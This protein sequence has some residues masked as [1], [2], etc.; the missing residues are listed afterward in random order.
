MSPPVADA[1]ENVTIRE[2]KVVILNGS[3]SHDNVGIDNYTWYVFIGEKVW[4]LWGTTAQFQFHIRGIYTVRLVVAD[5]VGLTDTDNLTV[6][7]LEK[8]DGDSKPP[9]DENDTDGDGWN[10]TIEQECGTDPNDNTSYPED[11]DDDG[12]PD[13]LDADIDGDGIPNEKDAYPRDSSRWKEED[14]TLVMILLILGAS[15]ILIVAGIMIYSRIKRRDILDNDT[16]EA[17]FNYI[18]DNPGSHAE[19][20]RKQLGIGDGTLR[21]HLRQLKLKGM[22]RFGREGRYKFFYP[23]GFGESQSLTPIQREII[24][25]LEHNEGTTAIEIARKLGKDRTTVLYHIDNLVDKGL[26]RSKKVNQRVYWYV[27]KNVENQ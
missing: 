3:G 2:G 8:D 12:I 22:V 10:N 21:H 16:R 24:D 18:T 14:S 1:G 25:I 26:L 5:N 15:C 20:I 6:T 23:S 19:K 9:D 13:K 17:V 27:Q 4:I 11:L 7:V